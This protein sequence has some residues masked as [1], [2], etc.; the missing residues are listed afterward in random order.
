[1][2]RTA[3]LALI[4]ILLTDPDASKI[5]TAIGLKKTISELLSYAEEEFDGKGL[6]VEITRNRSI[7]RFV[8]KMGFK[9]G[10]RDLTTLV[11]S[12]GGVSADFLME[13][14]NAPR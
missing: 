2:D 12:I 4:P 13:D 5:C 3:H 14:N 1:M 7:Q 6:V 11:Y 8:E 9:R 10:E